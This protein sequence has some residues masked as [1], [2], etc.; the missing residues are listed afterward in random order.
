M[1]NIAKLGKRSHEKKDE[2]RK[3]AR[4][5]EQLREDQKHN[6]YIPA[7]M[8]RFIEDLRTEVALLRSMVLELT[9]ERRRSNEEKEKEKTVANRVEFQFDTLPAN[10][11]TV[12]R[13]G[14]LPDSTCTLTYCV[15]NAHN[16]VTSSTPLP[17]DRPSKWQVYI[18][19]LRVSAWVVLGVMGSPSASEQHN[20]FSM[21]YAW[22]S[23]NCVVCAGSTK[24]SLGSWGTWQAGDLGTF[25][26]DP[27]AYTL[28]LTV[29]REGITQEFHMD[30]CVIPHA[31]I[32]ASFQKKGTSVRFSNIDVA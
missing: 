8:F 31:F 2:H 22:G 15:R 7:E 24:H 29:V 4:K 1:V 9:E 25:T 27:N 14:L 12:T 23:R 30:N 5:L 19:N 21:C 18:T 16:Y 13:D 6:N 26:Y 20:A 17:P 28:A 32:Y 3:L 10:L 11:V